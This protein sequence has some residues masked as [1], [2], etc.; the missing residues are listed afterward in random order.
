M[1]YFQN[2]SKKLI[3]FVNKLYSLY[4]L[5]K[6]NAICQRFSKVVALKF[7]SCHF[8]QIKQITPWVITSWRRWLTTMLLTDM[9]INIFL[10]KEAYLNPSPWL[11]QCRVGVDVAVVFFPQFSATNG[12]IG[13][14]YKWI[15]RRSHRSCKRT[16][17]WDF[18]FSE[19]SCSLSYA[20][21][22]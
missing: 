6:K 3:S 19:L 12:A 18:R 13:R 15:D 2:F 5:A 21:I 22:L 16:L 17:N 14:L 11:N 10:L 7:S 4:L 8:L 20:N 1:H 9:Q